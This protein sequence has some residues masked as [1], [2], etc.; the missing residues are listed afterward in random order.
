MKSAMQTVCKARTA[1]AEAAG[2]V[3]RCGGYESVASGSQ[4]HSDAD[5]VAQQAARRIGTT[6]ILTALTVGTQKKVIAMMGALVE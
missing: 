5:D 4:T 2:G 6:A 3:L 1:H